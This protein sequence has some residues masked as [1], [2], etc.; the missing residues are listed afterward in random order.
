MEFAYYSDNVEIYADS[1][2]VGFTFTFTG[3]TISRIVYD[4]VVV[5]RSLSE[6]HLRLQNWCKKQ[7][8]GEN[9]AY[10]H[11]VYRLDENDIALSAEWMAAKEGGRR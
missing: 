7:M 6:Q 9:P 5:R 4:T 10:M 8:V 3:D 11:L 1:K 2:H